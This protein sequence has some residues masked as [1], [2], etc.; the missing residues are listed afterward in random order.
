MRA[1]FVLA[2]S[3]SE[4]TPPPCR[5]P[6]R[7]RS[8]SGVGPPPILVCFSGDWD[9]HW[10]YGLL[11]HGHGGLRQSAK[12]LVVALASD[13]ISGGAQPACSDGR[14]D[15]EGQSVLPCYLLLRGMETLDAA[16]F[17][18]CCQSERFH[19]VWLSRRRVAVPRSADWRHMEPILT[20][21]VLLRPAAMGNQWYLLFSP[22]S[23]LVTLPCPKPRPKRLTFYFQVTEYSNDRLRGL[24]FLTQVMPPRPP[25]WPQ[26]RRRT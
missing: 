16:G 21:P 12:L 2:R 1:A 20:D 23:S 19:C 9:V 6:A 14:G 13:S 8:H 24:F 22:C 17:L 3:G 4:H 18:A 25:L 26:R 10:R 15:G 7:F 11:T 5:P